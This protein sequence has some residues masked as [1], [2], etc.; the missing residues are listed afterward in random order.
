MPKKPKKKTAE[1]RLEVAELHAFGQMRATVEYNAIVAREARE[2]FQQR[3][4]Q[5][6]RATRRRITALRRK[7]Q[8]CQTTT[9]ESIS[10]PPT[11]PP[12]TTPSD[13]TSGT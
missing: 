7:V 1:K 8:K 11:E 13:A 9:S 10:S 3:K 4:I 5:P 12:T 2:G 6:N